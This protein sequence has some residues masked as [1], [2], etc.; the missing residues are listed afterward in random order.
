MDE[1][2]KRK[3]TRQLV[4]WLGTAKRTPATATAIYEAMTKPRMS[5]EVKQQYKDNGLLDIR[6]SL[7]I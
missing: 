4:K 3:K 2:Q 1:E 7:G 6:G 5:K